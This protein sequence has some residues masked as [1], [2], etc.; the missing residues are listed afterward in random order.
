MSSEKSLQQNKASILLVDDDRLI[1]ATMATGLMQAGYEV[2]TTESVDDA[3]AWLESNPRPDIAIIDIN[4]PNR[5]GLELP[6]SL[7]RLDY[8]PFIFLTARSEPEVNAEAN[9]L[10]AMAYLV[11]PIDSAQLI[12]AIQTALSRAQDVK[13]MKS[14]QQQLQTA[15]DGDRAVSVAI[16]IIMDQYRI[17]YEEANSMLR[18]NARSKRIKL[19]DFATSI[20]H[21]RERLNLENDA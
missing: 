15:L 13:K 12:P 9:T 8:I 18:N 4:M 16:G 10:G 2:N 11:K 20:I 6:A 5:S 21:S 17:S 3:E 1:L 14:Q 7:D 19:V